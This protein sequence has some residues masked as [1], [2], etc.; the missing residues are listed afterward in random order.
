MKKNAKISNA[1]IKRLPRYRRYLYEL[2]KKGV[3]KGLGDAYFF[4]QDINTAVDESS[5]HNTLDHSGQQSSPHLLPFLFR[6]GFSPHSL[7]P[8]SKLKSKIQK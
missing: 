2:R 4:T 5:V 7:Q 3:E 8:H 1:V 6:I